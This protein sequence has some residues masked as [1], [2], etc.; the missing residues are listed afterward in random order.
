MCEQEGLFFSG[1]SICP[2]TPEKYILRAV[3]PAASQ[4]SLLHACLAAL[5]HI[6]KTTETAGRLPP[7]IILAVKAASSKAPDISLTS[8]S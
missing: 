6:S 5:P 4:A 7:L 3:S 2:L 1:T 8:Q